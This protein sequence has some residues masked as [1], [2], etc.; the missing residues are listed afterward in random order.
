MTRLAL[1]VPALFAVAALAGAVGPPAPARGD[2][3]PAGDTI[4]VTGTGSATAV[5]DDA[6]FS[7]GVDTRGDSA[8]AALAA[9][10]AAMRRLLAALRDAGARELATQ[11]VSVSPLSQA[12]G[13]VSGF[14]ASNSVSATIGVDRAGSL[15][16]A[17]VAVGANDVSG[18]DL[19]SA[20]AKR[21]YQQALG[22]AVADARAHAEILARAAGRSVGAITSMTEGGAQPVPVYRAAAADA[23]STPVVAGQQETTATVTVT[24]AL[25]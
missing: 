13:T 17:A 16:D 3:A 15:I 2:A 22:D 9:N 14:S 1:V 5:P 19:S 4:T 10:G 11:W 20:N 6:Q 18:P 7:F 12:D 24:F 23:S 21:L 25:R 8:Q